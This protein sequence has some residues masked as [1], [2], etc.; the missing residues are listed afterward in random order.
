MKNVIYLFIAVF[1]VSCGGA[2]TNNVYE[3]TISEYLLKGKSATDYNFKVIELSEQGSVTIAD[4][5]AYLTDEFRKDKQLIIKRIN[6]AKEMSEDLLA[7]EKK[8][9]AST[10]AMPILP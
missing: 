3:K 10:N 4:S 6:L 9:A 5:I 8:Q 7:R 1:L 2:G